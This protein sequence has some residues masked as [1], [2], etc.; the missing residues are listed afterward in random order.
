ML[1]AQIH[2]RHKAFHQRIARRAAALRPAPVKQLAKPAEVK[3]EPPA[4]APAPP[5]PVPN[6]PDHLMAEAIKMLSIPVWNHDIKK[7]Q[8]VVC[9]EYNISFGD[10][11]SHRR[12]NRL[13]LPR[14]VAMYLCS[15]LT[16][17][18]SPEI[19]RRFGD[20]DHTTVLHGVRKIER[21]LATDSAL[22]ARVDALAERLGGLV[23]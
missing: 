5:S 12:L 14:Q 16:V 4:P 9:E 8:Q 21:L 23:E 18:S 15:Q 10:L 17:R 19:G 2:E 1:L 20:R 6:V 13:V 11:V 22:R 3:V 7:I